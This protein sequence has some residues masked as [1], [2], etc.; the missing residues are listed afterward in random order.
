LRS[1]EKIS[2]IRNTKR[3][4]YNNENFL[5]KSCFLF[6]IIQI[7]IIF[8]YIF[9]TISNRKSELLNVIDWATIV[10]FTLTNQKSMFSTTI[11]DKGLA[12]TPIQDWL[13]GPF[14]RNQSIYHYSTAKFWFKIGRISDF[15]TLE[16]KTIRTSKAHFI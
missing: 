14:I 10:V 7:I 11:A 9:C 13:T 3:T 2:Y 1:E 12:R 16:K 6:L 8:K 15:L 4:K 5:A